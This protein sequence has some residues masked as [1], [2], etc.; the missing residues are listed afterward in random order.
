MRSGDGQSIPWGGVRALP[1]PHPRVPPLGCGQHPTERSPPPA[2]LGWGWALPKPRGDF[3]VLMGGNTREMLGPA[4]PVSCGMLGMLAGGWASSA[5]SLLPHPQ[6]L[7]RRAAGYP[8]RILAAS[9]PR[10]KAKRGQPPLLLLVSI[11]STTSAPSAEWGGVG[12]VL[13]SAFPA[14]LP[15]A[16]GRQRDAPRALRVSP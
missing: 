14:S 15:S 13:Q 4:V 1:S 2:G 9:R 11:P 7:S 10:D 3:G 12:R 5:L 6:S 8:R 16:Q